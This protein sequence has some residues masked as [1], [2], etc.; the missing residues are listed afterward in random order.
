MTKQSVFNPELERYASDCFNQVAQARINLANAK[1]TEDVLLYK[2][3]RGESFITNGYDYWFLKNTNLKRA[4]IVTIID[5][6]G[7]KYT[8]FNEKDY[9]PGAVCSI[10]DV[11]NVF[12]CLRKYAYRGAIKV[13]SDELNMN[14]Q[15]QEN[16]RIEEEENDNDLIESLKSESDFPYRNSINMKE[17]RGYSSSEEEDENGNENESQSERVKWSQDFENNSMVCDACLFEHP[18]AYEIIR[19]LGD[20]KSLTK[21]KDEFAIFIFNE[22]IK[23][24]KSKIRINEDSIV[25]EEKIPPVHFAGQ[26][27][28]CYYK[29]EVDNAELFDKKT[30]SLKGYTNIP[31]IPYVVHPEGYHLKIELFN[32]GFVREEDFKIERVSL[33]EKYIK[34]DFNREK[35]NDSED[36]EDDSEDSENDSEDSEDDSEDSENDSEDSDT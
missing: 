21:K 2:S 3:Y 15:K 17:I 36:S 22:E 32:N 24:E 20:S 11:K 23:I 13:I 12:Q 18:T 9:G 25:F 1:L 35:E 28:V 6:F 8:G 10:E 31:P 4:A 27:K 16:A 14:L 30:L 29:I 33:K 34:K 19:C 26:G 7:A 5:Y